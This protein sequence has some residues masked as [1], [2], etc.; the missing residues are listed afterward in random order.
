MS[1]YIMF[2]LVAALKRL[3]HSQD[4]SVAR[5]RERIEAFDRFFKMLDEHEQAAFRLLFSIPAGATGADL[6][7]PL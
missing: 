6:T 1:F 2:D 7:K 5:R 4:L 3:K